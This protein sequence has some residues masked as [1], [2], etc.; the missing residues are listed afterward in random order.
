MMRRLTRMLRGTGRGAAEPFPGTLAVAGRPVSAI[1]LLGGYHRPGITKAGRLSLRGT[2]DGAAVKVYSA[3]SA[4]QVRLRRALQDISL[5]GGICLPEIVASDDTLVA[6]RWVEGTPLGDLRGRALSDAAEQV[7]RF[8]HGCAAAPDLQAL[9]GR[10]DGAFCYL[11]NYLLPRLGDWV[12]VCEIGGFVAHWRNAYAAVQPRLPRRLSHPDLS[13]AN[14]ILE[15]GSGRLFI[16]DNELLGVGG[17]WLLDWHNSLL[18]DREIPPLDPPPAEFAA[19][20]DLTWRLRRLGSALDA[21]DF[22]RAL[23]TIA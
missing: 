14:L 2:C 16:V 6:E 20:V 23:Q 8:L 17:G 18:R 12:H 1:R 10:F 13:L 3:H 15:K 19:F 11:E 7:R 21:G 22:R 5:P 9:A 4:A